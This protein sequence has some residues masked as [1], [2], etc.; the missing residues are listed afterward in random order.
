MA[1]AAAT[2]YGVDPK[3]F[4][5]QINQES[6]FNPNARS[7]A[8]A[9]G[10]AQFM[11]GTAASYHIDPMDPAQALDAAAH[12]DANELKAFGGDYH[13]ALAAYNAGAGNAD[14]WNDPNFAHGQTYNYVRSILGAAGH[15]PTGASAKGASAKG[16]QVTGE[17]AATG[18]DAPDMLRQLL[19][20]S[21]LARTSAFASGQNA[22][23]QS[24][25]LPM[26][27]LMAT[28]GSQ[29]ASMVSPPA[30]AKASG[31]KPSQNVNTFAGSLPFV[32]AT[33][34]GVKS[35]LLSHLTAAV[36]A[37]GGDA[38]KLTSGYRSAAHNQSVGGV[39]HSNHLTGD[40]VD[41]YA[42]ING[43]WVPL[44]V[45]IKAVAAKYGLRSG[46][47]PG[48]FNGGTDPVHVDDGANV[49]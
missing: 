22:P 11:P 31:G 2:K 41:G 47:Q 23:P 32:G 38:I 28:L 9:S 43:Q 18:T 30:P 27:Q 36:K 10:I 26:M 46:D 4:L 15:T 45:A 49:R 44:G 24:S 7:G 35:G 16:A 42:R 5:A 29:G 21:L 33:T 37:S 39:S 8:G 6:G 20:S 12:Y 13:K 17:T 14:K 3:V 40:A 25:M 1:S 48:F 34:Q 19:M